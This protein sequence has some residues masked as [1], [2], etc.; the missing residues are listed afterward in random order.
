VLLFT[1]SDCL[2]PPD[3]IA[4]AARAFEDPSLAAL[5]GASVSSGGRMSRHA[6]LEYERYVASHA[7]CGFRHFC[8]LRNFAVRARIVRD[9]PL[10]DRFPR[11]GDGVYGRRLEAA[12][13]RIRYE[14]SWTITHRHPT[15]RWRE[16][17]RAFEEGRC[18]ALW[19]SAEDI[20]LFGA[21]PEAGPGAWLLR[22]TARSAAA[23]QVASIL[24][25]PV[26]ALLAASSAILPDPAA[27]AAF[28]RFRRAAHLSGRLAG[29][30]AGR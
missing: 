6:Q 24:L 3:W 14:P 29:E 1:D 22:A 26:A 19:K 20:D 5:Q 23:R 16:G 9:L 15:T 30:S 8:N 4:R 27:A 21:P 25:V 17:A 28:S 13:I 18:G 2:C 12:G 11:G 7:A 10:P